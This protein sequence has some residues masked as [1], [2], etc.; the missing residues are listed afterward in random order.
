[1]TVN[2]TLPTRLISVA[3][4][5]PHLVLTAGWELKPRFCTLS[6]CWGSKPFLKL[7]DDNYESFLTRIPI[8]ELPRT[9]Q[10]A[11]HISRKFGVDYLWIDSLCIIQG[12]IEDWRREAGLMSNV[13]GASYI[14]IAA[15]SATSVHEGCFLKEP[16]M[17]DGLRARININGDK[18]VREFRGSGLY[19]RSVLKSHLATRAWALQEKLL[20]PRTIHFG[21]RGAFW[22]CRLET[23]N[24]FLPNGFPG[25]Y[26][27]SLIGKKQRR[28]FQ[29]WWELVVR[30]YSA[31][32]LTFQSDKLP[33]IA[34]IARSV[35]KER[36]G[37][38]LAGMWRENLEIQLCWQAQH[39]QSKP[40][41]RAPS[42]AWASASGPTS[43]YYLV[44]A[45][46]ILY[47]MYTQVIEAQTVP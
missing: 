37:Q 13:Y 43:Y 19:H 35:A 45:G 31:A 44:A 25:D 30:L 36:G 26:T 14:N 41:W 20:P 46:F 9:F 4:P 39:P 22:E 8:G 5:T 15:S 29:I 24:E 32:N 6:H 42:W 16:H 47:N 28:H 18:Y 10:D 27:F 1:M 23:A 2:E 3:G 17:V 21:D 12:N 33:A 34:G 38:Y 7:T 11:I 40:Q